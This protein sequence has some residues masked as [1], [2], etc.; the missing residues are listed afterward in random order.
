MTGKRIRPCPPPGPQVARAPPSLPGCARPSSSAGTAF[1]VTAPP[2][3]VSPLARSLVGTPKPCSARA[4]CAHQRCSRVAADPAFGILAFAALRA[5][6]WCQ[7]ED[8]GE[9]N[10]GSKGG[11]RSQD[12]A[13]DMDGFASPSSSVRTTVGTATM[14]RNRSTDIHSS[15]TAIGHRAAPVQAGCDQ[16]SSRCARCDGVNASR[17]LSAASPAPAAPPAGFRA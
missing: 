1:V 9:A 8:G 17:C 7:A 4:I 15:P 13:G 14:R 2:T 16:R 3:A 10:P 11:V 6:W 5:A 12:R